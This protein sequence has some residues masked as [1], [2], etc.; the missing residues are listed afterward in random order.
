[1]KT[2]NRTL[3]SLDEP[4]GKINNK[5]LPSFKLD[6]GKADVIFFDEDLSGF[7]YRLRRSGEQ[8]RRS[9]VVQYRSKGRT[10]RVLIGSAEVLKPD[11]AQRQRNRS[12]PRSPS[13]VIRR[14][15]RYRPGCNRP[16]RCAV[17]WT[18]IWKLGLLSYG[19]PPC[20]S[21]NST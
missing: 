12:W 17:W 16:V 1:M 14:P 2:V 9:Y 6:P 4:P 20:G 10:R 8:V 5:T 3:P 7:G 18:A 11:Q 13:G 15:T 19:R 21:L